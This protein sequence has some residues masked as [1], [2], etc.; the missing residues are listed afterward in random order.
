MKILYDNRYV[1][2]FLTEVST[3]SHCWRFVCHLRN[4]K[5]SYFFLKF[6]LIKIFREK[7]VSTIIRDYYKATSF[8]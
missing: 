1:R 6:I 8:A 5:I 4:E 2:F 3:M 7:L